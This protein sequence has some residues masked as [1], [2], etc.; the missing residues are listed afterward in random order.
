MRISICT[1]QRMQTLQHIGETRV[2][3]PYH[4]GMV[5][6]YLHLVD[7]YGKCVQ[8]YYTWMVWDCDY[9]LLQRYLTSWDD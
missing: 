7:F 3:F 4:P 5:H 1:P 9:G 2:G 6:I 8:I